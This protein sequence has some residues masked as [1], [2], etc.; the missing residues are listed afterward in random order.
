MFAVHVD[1]ERCTW[2]STTAGCCRLPNTMFRNVWLAAA[3]SQGRWCGR[4][5]DTPAAYSRRTMNAKRTRCGIAECRPTDGVTVSD[6]WEIPIRAADKSNER[7]RKTTSSGG[8]W[9]GR[10]QDNRRHRWRRCALRSRWFCRTA[11]RII[12]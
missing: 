2:W 3:V 5:V 11:K 12:L 1:D 4:L 8:G 9:R 7:S 6:R 10:V